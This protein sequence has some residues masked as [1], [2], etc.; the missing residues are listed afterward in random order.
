MS[1]EPSLLP[2]TTHS[3]KICDSKLDQNEFKFTKIEENE[4]L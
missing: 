3:Q 4:E 1:L 2:A